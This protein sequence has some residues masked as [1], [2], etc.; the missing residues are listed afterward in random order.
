MIVCPRIQFLI[1]KG[2]IGYSS[3]VNV[4]QLTYKDIIGGFST[5]YPREGFIFLQQNGTNLFWY[6]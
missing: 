4:N 2:E 1:D 6:Q 5:N 3:A